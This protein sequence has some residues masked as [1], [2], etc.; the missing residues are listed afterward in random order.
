MLKIVSRIDRRAPARRMAPNDEP[1]SIT[2]RWPRWNQTRCGI[3]WTSGW[4]PVAIE[5]RQTGVSEGNVDVALPY[6]PR[7]AS[8]ARAGEPPVTARSNIDGVSPS[9]TTRTS[10]LELDSAG[11]SAQAGVAL[12]ASLL[13][14]AGEHRRGDRLQIAHDRH[15]RQSRADQRGRAGDRVTRFAEQ[16][17]GAQPGGRADEDRRDQAGGPAAEKRG[18]QHAECDAE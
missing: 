1:Y 12:D 11:K 9:M 14:A 2:R 10:F 6:T 13:R 3:S 18:G 5:E 4:A 15:E 17:P 16:E 8:A 7:S